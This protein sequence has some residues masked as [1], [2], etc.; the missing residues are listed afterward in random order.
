NK[1]TVTFDKAVTS[2]SAMNPANYTVDG[3]ALPADTKIVVEDD[4]TVEF[5]LP[6]G[7][8]AEDKDNAKVTVENIVPVDSNA[9]FSPYA[10]ASHSVLDNTAPEASGKL[11]K[12]GE[13]FLTFSEKVAN[14]VEADFD[15][16]IVNDL[17]L[18]SSAYSF[19]DEATEDGEQ[20]AKIEVEAKTAEQSGIT[21]L[22]IDVD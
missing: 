7:F 22:Y 9:K 20:A 13:I 5:E 6:A 10:E 8:I 2:E 15:Q 4:Q 3:K 11:L 17:V 18:D 19:A 16:V 21:Y 1:F 12:N 14:V